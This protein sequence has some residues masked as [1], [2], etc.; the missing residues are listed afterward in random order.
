MS[1]AVTSETTTTETGAA[2]TAATATGAAPGPVPA[3][4][5]RSHSARDMFRSLAVLMIP[6]LVIGALLK[7]CGS[8]DATVID[9][10]QAIADARAADFFDVVVPRDLP[11]GWRV[12]SASFRRAG[13]VGTLRLGYLTPSG[14]GVQLVLSNAPAADL[15]AQELGNETRP[16]G[17]V[18]VAGQAW[19]SSIVRGDERA[20]VSTTA[21]RTIVVVG[22]ATLDDLTVLAGAL[23]VP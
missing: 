4:M 3:N 1:D 23:R 13:E 22:R 12:V 5:R 9:P 19:T 6:I 10:T 15:L 21:A 11:E 8:Q 7:A 18:S 17:E 20:L 16:Q 14:D 2:G